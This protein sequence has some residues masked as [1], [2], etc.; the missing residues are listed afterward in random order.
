MSD[1]SVSV[2]KNW[3]HHKYQALEDDVATDYR[4]KKLSL[5]E[6]SQKHGIPSDSTVIKILKRKGVERR[7]ISEGLRLRREKKMRR[8]LGVK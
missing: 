6:I 3:H 2:L 8:R 4:D 5:S 7:S 1:V